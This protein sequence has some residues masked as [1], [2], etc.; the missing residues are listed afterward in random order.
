MAGKPV[1]TVLSCHTDEV[2]LRL[3]EHTKDTMQRELALPELVPQKIC[4]VWKINLEVDL[5]FHFEQSSL[6]WQVCTFQ[7]PTSTDLFCL[8]IKIKEPTCTDDSD[9]W[10]KFGAKFT[11]HMHTYTHFHAH[12]CMCSNLIL[13]NTLTLQAE[14]KN[15]QNQNLPIADTNLEMQNMPNTV[16]PRLQC[17]DFTGYQKSC[18]NG[19][20]ILWNA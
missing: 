9:T 5:Y 19:R 3:K 16:T 6:P 4:K 7:T 11:L 2:L 20:E 1:G 14:Q 18:R 13:D 15:S 8:S 17:W 10:Q 12:M